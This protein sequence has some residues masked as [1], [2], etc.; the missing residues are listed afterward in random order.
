MFYHCISFCVMLFL[1]YKIFFFTPN[2]QKFSLLCFVLQ[3]L[4]IYLLHFTFEIFRINF[5]VNH[6][7]KS[8]FFLMHIQWL[9]HYLL[10]SPAFTCW[11]TL[12]PF[13]NIRQLCRWVYS[14]TLFCNSVLSL[15]QYHIVSTIYCN[16]Y[17]FWYSMLW[18]SFSSDVLF[19]NWTVII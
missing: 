17:K 19:L 9:P 14:W 3:V 7:W 8:H 18:F 13:S 16:L 15:C 4:E 2:L 6:R 12:A 10:K 11:I 5:C 1:T